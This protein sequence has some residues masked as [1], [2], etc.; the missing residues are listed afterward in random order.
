[1]KYYKTPQ[2]KKWPLD[3]STKSLVL[4]KQKQSQRKVW[5]PTKG[6]QI[7]RLTGLLLCQP[8]KTFKPKH[9]AFDSNPSYQIEI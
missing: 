8:L 4:Y 3:V 7:A 9:I 6:W 2:R 1:M 5:I